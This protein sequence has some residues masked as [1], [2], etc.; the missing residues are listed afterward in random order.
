MQ[1]LSEELTLPEVLPATDE[2]IL[3]YLRRACKRS[4]IAYLSE[5]D[6]VV[7]KVCEQLGITVSEAE[8]QAA[9]EAFRLKYKLLSVTETLAWFD[10]QK[11]TVEAWSEGVRVVL[12]TQ[13]LKEALFGQ[14]ID[15]QYM[16]NRENFRRVALSQVLVRDLVNALKIVQALRENGASFCAIAIENSLGKQSKESGG[17]VGIR[18]LSELL[19]EIAQAVVEA[20]EFEVLEP[21]QTKLGYHVIRVEKWFPAQLSEIREQILES[22]F[23]AWLQKALKV[24]SNL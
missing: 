15:G 4:E 16:E 17:F 22:L 7:L 2:E 12:L 18:F 8:L 5:K 24:D 14:A 21:I 11:T 6:A 19:P 9:G 23:Q 20:K 10:Q 1:T 13:K 3:N